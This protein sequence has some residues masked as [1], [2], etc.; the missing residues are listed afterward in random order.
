MTLRGLVSC[1]K[2]QSDGVGSGVEIEAEVDISAALE[3]RLEQSWSVFGLAVV[4]RLFFF[5]G[6]AV[7][8]A[9]KWFGGPFF[10][11]ALQ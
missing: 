1:I 7:M 4:W 10:S 6:F 5:A 9:L 8:L 3:L 2:T 11:P